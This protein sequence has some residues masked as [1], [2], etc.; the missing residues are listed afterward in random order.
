MRALAVSLLLVFAAAPA[1]SRDRTPDDPQ[2]ALA[3]RLTG[4]TPGHPISCLP[5]SDTRFAHTQG[6]GRTI[7]YEVTRNFV[8][9]T[10]TAGGCESM[11]HGDIIVVRSNGGQ[12]C[13][14]DVAET[15]DPA[16]RTPTG[17][18]SLG[19]FTPY[20]RP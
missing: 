3:K 16:S 5:N 17:S 7:L 11:A 6:Y 10:D 9:R 14:G 1:A 19:E 20:R 13:R 12:V 15:I 8:Y 18:C 2:A 4:L